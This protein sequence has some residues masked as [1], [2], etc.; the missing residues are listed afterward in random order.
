MFSR[1][2]VVRR[3]KPFQPNSMNM[4]RS[5]GNASFPL[6]VKSKTLKDSGRSLKRMNNPP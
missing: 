1:T 2:Y 6:L 4:L 5:F 3:K